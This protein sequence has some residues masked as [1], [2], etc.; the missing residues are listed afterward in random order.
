MELSIIERTYSSWSLR[1]WLAVELTGAPCA[2][3]SAPKGS[4]AFAR[5]CEDNR[6]ALTVPAMRFDDGALVWESSAI[7]EELAQRWPEA[8]LWPADPVARGAARSLANEMHAGFGALR[9][10][11]PMNLARRYVGF[12]PSV[13]VLEDVARIEDLW[14]WAA[15]RFGGEGPWLFGARPCAA[16]VMFAPVIARFV[17]Y[18]LGESE[19][20]ARLQEA[21]YAWGPFRRW[22]AMG[23]AEKRRIDEY[24]F[25]LPEARRFG[26]APRPARAIRPDEGRTPV[27]EACPYSGRPVAADSLAEIDGRAIGFCNPFCRDKSVADAE[28]WPKLAPLLP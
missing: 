6:P 17:T 5:L 15:E 11:C 3:R 28:A 1:A 24:E 9:A 19:V 14:T 25:D 16:D 10:A 27:N 22:R 21:L 20:T 12:E 13:E 7:I 2:V 23:V 8:G 26:P 4:E 18:G